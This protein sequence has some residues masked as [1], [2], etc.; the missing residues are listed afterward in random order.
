MYQDITFEKHDIVMWRMFRE[1]AK[2]TLAKIAVIHGICY[3][4]FEFIRW[5]CYDQK[6]AISKIYKFD[7]RTGLKGEHIAWMVK[8]FDKGIKDKNGESKGYYTLWKIFP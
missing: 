8:L 3:K 5:T 1:S 6:K 4:K 2:T 7:Q